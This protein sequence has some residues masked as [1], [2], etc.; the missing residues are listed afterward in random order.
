MLTHDLI[1]KKMRSKRNKSKSERPPVS[2]ISEPEDQA[3]LTVDTS[4]YDK[5]N[6][7]IIS[8]QNFEDESEIVDNDSG[9]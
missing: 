1:V 9:D 2:K 5:N 8:N 6:L 3:N 7:S 4:V